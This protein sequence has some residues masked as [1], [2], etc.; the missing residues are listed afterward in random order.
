MMDHY[1]DSS[2]ICTIKIGIHAFYNK[3]IAVSLASLQKENYA[4]FEAIIP[5]FTKYFV[6]LA[7]DIVCEKL[8]IKNKII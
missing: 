5:P 6:G 3:N 8:I 1:R 2:V 4:V 7:G